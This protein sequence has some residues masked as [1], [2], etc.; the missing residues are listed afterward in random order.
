MWPNLFLFL[1]FPPAHPKFKK[2]S[3]YDNAPT[4]FPPIFLLFPLL[5]LQTAELG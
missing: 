3:R 2:F 1:F 4:L 5:Q